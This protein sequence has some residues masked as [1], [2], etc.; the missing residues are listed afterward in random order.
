MAKP[1]GGPAKPAGLPTALAAAN[2]DIDAARTAAKNLA[3][4]APTPEQTIANINTLTPDVASE[5]N[6]RAM[7]ERQAQRVKELEDKYAKS[8]PSALDDL[9]RVFGQAGQY[10]GLS[11][12]GPAYTQNREAQRADELNFQ[13]KMNA[14]RSGMEEK[15]LEGATK[16]RDTRTKAFDTERSEYLRGLQA[17]AK[18]LADIAGVSQQAIDNAAKN[19]TSIEVAKINAAATKRGT[20]TERLL[21]QYISLKAKDPKAAAKLLAAVTEMKQAGDTPAYLKDEGYKVA[22]KDLAEA[23]KNLANIP[24]DSKLRKPREDAVKA[25]EALVA[26]YKSGAVGSK[27]T[28]D[29]SDLLSKA[30]AILAGSK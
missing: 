29:N 11:G 17:R 3:T 18:S 13:A 15:E 5:G 12:L 14:L 6:Q 2:P 30:D 20:P 7:Y 26:D 21:D 22:V 23:R 19:L 28:G 1:Q 27:N 4:E 10:K 24:A 16:L 25:L 9:I 8:R